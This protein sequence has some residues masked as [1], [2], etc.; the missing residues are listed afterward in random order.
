MAQEYEQ[1]KKVNNDEKKIMSN[2]LTPTGRKFSNPMINAAD[3]SDDCLVDS[4]NEE[5]SSIDED[6]PLIKGS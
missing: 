1:S 3:D 5:T 6:V 4:E 2:L